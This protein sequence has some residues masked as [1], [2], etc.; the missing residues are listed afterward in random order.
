MRFLQYLRPGGYLPPHIDLN[1][2]DHEGDVS[3]HTFILYLDTCHQGGETVLLDSLIT[4][5]I[6]DCNLI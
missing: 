6:C 1:R 4:Y 2:T 5:F 3:T